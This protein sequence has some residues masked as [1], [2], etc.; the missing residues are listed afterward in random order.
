[1]KTD[2]HSF[3]ACRLKLS[4]QYYTCIHGIYKTLTDIH[5]RLQPNQNILI[6]GAFTSLKSAPVFSKYIYYHLNE[7]SLIRELWLDGC[8]G[9]VDWYHAVQHATSP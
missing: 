7:G 6:S 4:L 3:Q 2:E 5:V 1:M 9:L 8:C